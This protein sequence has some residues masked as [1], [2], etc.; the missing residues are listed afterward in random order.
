MQQ[1]CLGYPS[2]SLDIAIMRF[3]YTALALAGLSAAAPQ[4]LPATQY[5]LGDH[6]P[7]SPSFDDR[8]PNSPGFEPGVGHFSEWSRQT[9]KEFLIDWQSGRMADWTLVQGNEGGDL[10]SMAAALTW[11]YHLEHSTQNTS[12]PTRAIA[13]LQTP[14]DA[15]DLRPE[16]KVAL[17]NSQMSSGH[18]DLL[19]ID[20]LPE[21]PET[22]SRKIKGIVIVDHAVPLR[23]WKNA[24]VLS[25][26]D[27]HAD[28]GV[29]P[30]AEPRIFEQVA[31]CTTLVTRQMLDELEALPEEY[32]M[33]HELLELVLSAIAIDSKGLKEGKATDADIATSARV[34]KRSAWR[35]RKLSH[36]MEDLEDKL[37]KAQD[38]ID[39]LG[40]RDLLRR[41]WKG[42]L[43]DTPSPRTPTINLGFASIPY[44]LSNQ[45][46][47]TSYEELFDW[48]AIEAA[49]TAETRTDISV[50]LTKYKT[51]TH[52]GK[53]RKVREI[54]LIVRDNVR[55][56]EE[57]A[58]SLFETVSKAI[59]ADQG[60]NVKSWDR[61]DELGKR[62][63]VWV[64]GEDSNAGRKVVRPLVEKAVM[65]WDMPK[66]VEE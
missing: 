57:Q 42:D 41:D 59:E 61:A 58:D 13:L 15:L 5:H 28:R 12:K 27:H 36:V 35:K 43:V 33:P 39:M 65:A 45:I 37:S 18:S 23:K 29:A 17:G 9:K 16:N 64:Q 56:D 20:E 21:D 10:D 63:M 48:F 66:T 49:W 6:K 4:I 38:D 40:L 3:T 1:L 53:K 47:K 19:T 54:A 32:H 8:N 62:Q 50:V 7:N 22:L 46:R 11:A 51:K 60:L 34:L 44:S 55:I 14:V 2:S 24:K 30:D 31:S 25:I 52:K 26:F